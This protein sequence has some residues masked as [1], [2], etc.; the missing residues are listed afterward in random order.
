MEDVDL[1]VFKNIFGDTPF[2]SAGGWNDKN[3]WGVLE[4][5]VYDALAIGR[6]FLSTP[7][8][9]D[10]YVDRLTSEYTKLIKQQTQERSATECLRSLSVLWSI[11][12]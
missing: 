5:G 4:E 7:D 12:G 3:A 9:I 2:I 11:P 8:M 1:R 6:L 10:R